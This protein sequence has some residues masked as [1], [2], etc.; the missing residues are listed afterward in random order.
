MVSNKHANFLINRGEATEKDYVTLMT[1]VRNNVAEATGLYLRPEVVFADRRSYESVMNSTY[2]PKVLVLYGGNSR[3][4]EISIQ[5]GS[6]S[7]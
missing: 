4:R 1:S 6:G 2:I 3:E 7:S 5:S